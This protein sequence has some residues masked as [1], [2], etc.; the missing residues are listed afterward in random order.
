M[1]QLTVLWL[2]S[3]KFLINRRKLAP[4]CLEPIPI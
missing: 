4:I 1:R 2:P 3:S